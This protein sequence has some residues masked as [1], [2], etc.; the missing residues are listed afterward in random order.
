MPMNMES[1]RQQMVTQQ[2]R[3]WAVLDAAVLRVLSEVPRERFVPPAF[4]ALAFADTAIPLPEGQQMLTPQVEG[5]LLQ[6]LEV[7]PT[8]AVLEIGTGSGFL[9]AC[10]ARLGSHVTSLEIRPAIAEA[11]RR[12]LREAGVGNCEVEVADAFQWRPPRQFNCIALSGSLPVFDPRFQDW[13]APGGRLFAVVGQAP[14]M[15]ACL[16]RRVDGGE[17]I[18]ES[19]FETVLPA[20][21]HA[22]R[23]EPFAF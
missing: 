13:L 15:D 9:A 11:A 1:A 8:D 2:V 18:R 19:L 16:I 17:F 6:A 10:L 5:R 22:P 21:D 23:P 12:K 4:A 7:S 14:A 3:A 20:L